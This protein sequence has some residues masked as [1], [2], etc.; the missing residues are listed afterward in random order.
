MADAYKLSNI[1][2]FLTNDRI[3]RPLYASFLLRL[4]TL[5]VYE[6]H[7]HAAYVERLAAR[8]AR[9]QTVHASS[10]YF[11]LIFKPS[12]RMAPN[13]RPKD[14]LYCRLRSRIAPLLARSRPAGSQCV[15]SAV[16]NTTVALNSSDARDGEFEASS[17]TATPQPPVT[18]HDIATQDATAQN[19]PPLQETQD[20]ANHVSLPAVVSSPSASLK[21]AQTHT[22]ASSSPS[23]GRET[24]QEPVDPLSLLPSGRRESLRAIASAT[25]APQSDPTAHLIHDGSPSNSA[26][27]ERDDTHS[28]EEVGLPCERSPSE[29]GVSSP[30]FPPGLPHASDAAFAAGAQSFVPPLVAAIDRLGDRIDSISTTV[31]RGLQDINGSVGR[32]A[33]RLDGRHSTGVTT[34]QLEESPTASISYTTLD[35][36]AVQEPAM[37]HTTDGPPN[38]GAWPSPVPLATMP[39]PLGAG[40]DIA[41]L[42]AQLSSIGGVPPNLLLAGGEVRLPAGTE[43]RSATPDGRPAPAEEEQ[44][45][46]EPRTHRL[47]AHI[48]L[49]PDDEGQASGCAVQPEPRIG[50]QDNHSSVVDEGPTTDANANNAADSVPL[51]AIPEVSIIAPTPLDRE[52]EVLPVRNPADLPSDFQSPTAA[53]QKAKPADAGERDGT[54]TGVD[55]GPENEDPASAADLASPS[56]SAEDSSVDNPDSTAAN[57]QVELTIEDDPIWTLIVCRPTS[58]L[59]PENLQLAIDVGTD[60]QVQNGDKVLFLGDL[61][62]AT[63]RLPG[64]CAEREIEWSQLYLRIRKPVYKRQDSMLRV[65]DCLRPY[66]RCFLMVR[67]IMDEAHHINSSGHFRADFSRLLFLS[68]EGKASKDRA[69]LFP[70][71]QLRYLNLSSQMG[72]TEMIQIIA[73][74]QKL[75]LLQLQHQ[76]ELANRHTTTAMPVVLPQNVVFPPSMRITTNDPDSFLLCLRVAESTTTDLRLRM[77]GGPA[78]CSNELKTVLSRHDGWTFV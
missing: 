53:P 6:P 38:P 48:M 33:G 59:F 51:P 31:T 43:G 77:E 57:A 49:P 1:V 36:S 70:L 69:L 10:S 54:A 11:G 17:D 16:S 32:I 44:A 21:S 29:P 13:S 67:F 73:A 23:A 40:M 66:L 3:S 34:P 65:M 12:P 61:E 9:A 55:V 72:I 39:S 63:S 76:K 28:T 26:S 7:V 68:V 2:D 14:G 50:L 78:S 75:D 37:I 41:A 25:A 56:P 74:A 60:G 22:S 4:F 5:L 47:R 19:L 35:A 24:S 52:G 64:I 58:E 46:D 42:Q 45:T 27:A 62:G 8:L 71:N 20:S 18:G 15:V 30:D